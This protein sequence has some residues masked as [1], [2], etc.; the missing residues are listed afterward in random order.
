MFYVQRVNETLCKKGKFGIWR[1]IFIRLFFN[2]QFLSKILANDG[3]R[4][5]LISRDRPK[6]QLD[7]SHEH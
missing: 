5:F 1:T 2:V 4:T 6:R 3:L 7:K